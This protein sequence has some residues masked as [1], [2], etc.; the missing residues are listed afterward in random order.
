MKS[1]SFSAYQDVTNSALNNCSCESDVRPLVVNCTGCFV[2]QKPFTTYNREGRLDYY[3]MH[4]LSGSLTLPIHG[5]EAVATRGSVIVFPPHY[6]YTYTYSGGEELCYEWVHFT[7]RDAEA[8]L[9]ACGFSRFPEICV[10]PN[11]SR[12]PQHFQML[13]DAFSTQDAFRDREASA[14]LECLLISLGRAMKQT[15]ETQKSL[16]VSM[17]YIMTSYASEIQIPQ[18][19]AMEHMSTPRYNAHFKALTGISPSKYILQLRIASACDLLRNTDMSVKEIAG[20]CGYRDPYFFSRA[21]KAYM[22]V[23]P[24]GYRSG[25]RD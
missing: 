12:V 8:A 5:G 19:A 10:I 23:S 3:L 1:Y 14:M 25:D 18:L 7:G 6:R 9:C 11:A 21:F 17:H 13:F 22:G 15:G 24:K 20:L 16:S 4:V 2:T